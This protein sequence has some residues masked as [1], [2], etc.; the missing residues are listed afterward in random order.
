MRTD[1]SRSTLFFTL[2][3]T[4]PRL[5]LL[6]LYLNRRI[7]AASG[8][9][10]PYIL[11]WLLSPLSCPAVSS[12]SSTSLTDS[13]ASRPRSLLSLVHD[14]WTLTTPPASPPSST[15]SPEVTLQ[16]DLHIRLAIP[17]SFGLSHNRMTLASLPV[18]VSFS[19]GH[20]KSLLEVRLRGFPYVAATAEVA[21]GREVVSHSSSCGDTPL[22]G[23][24][25]QRRPKSEGFGLSSFLYGTARGHC[26]SQRPPSIPR[27]PR[28]AIRDSQLCLS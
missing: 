28:L 11:F 19:L 12:S 24:S 9:P 18:S 14:S 8:H 13:H 15:D 1:H 7:V 23:C 26:C 5:H 25:K 22:V 17:A 27:P 21:I 20:P 4:F 6:L 10:A 3:F 2:E 16:H